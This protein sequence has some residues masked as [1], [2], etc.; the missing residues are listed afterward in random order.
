MKG[1]KEA[2]DAY[3][4]GALDE[5]LAIQQQVVGARE[6]EPQA[7]DFLALCLILHARKDIPKAIEVLRDGLRLHPESAELHENL[8]TCLLLMKQAE[9]GVEELQRA[10]ALGSKSL[11]LYD[12]LCSGLGRLGR[13]PEGLV[14]GRKSLEAKH[15]RF[16]AAAPL[17][18][19]PQGTPPPFDASKP[20]QNVISYV[21]WGDQPRYHV[22]LL[23]NLRL[24]NHLFPAWTIRVYA[25]RSVPPELVK[26]LQRSGAQLVLREQPK[27]EPAARRLLWRFEVIA[28]PA[29]KRF[30]VRDADSILSVKERVA[31]DDW[32]RSPKYFHVMRDFRTHTDLMLAGMWGGVGGILPPPAKLWEQFKPWRA[33]TDHIDQ[34]LLTVTVWPTLKQSC[35]IHDSVFT[36]CLGSVPF[37]PY[38]E[39]PAGHHVGQN[40][41]I[42]FKQ[43]K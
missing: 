33:E 29:V 8:G 23:E 2:L 12:G 37:P 38:G 6:P 34:D 27:N 41:F 18:R 9:A 14:H 20:E 19:I 5:A 22:P 16:G 30:L 3:R 10:L 25:D 32:L 28:D 13:E 24:R 11:N 26:E 31:V 21:L 40:A 1:R 17:A 43:D 36:G 35:L 39:L 4:R 42:H 7:E 15:A